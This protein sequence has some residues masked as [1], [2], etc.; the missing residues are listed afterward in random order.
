MFLPRWIDSNATCC[1]FKGI[2]KLRMWSIK[3]SL[4]LLPYGSLKLYITIPENL[5]MLSLPCEWNHGSGRI[6]TFQRT[7]L[8]FK[9]S[10]QR[11]NVYKRGEIASEIRK[12]A[13]LLLIARLALL[14]L[15]AH[16]NTECLTN[17]Q[18][19]ASP[20]EIAISF[21]TKPVKW[22]CRG[23]AHSWKRGQYLVALRCHGNAYRYIDRAVHVPI[24][25][26]S[27]LIIRRQKLNAAF[28]STRRHFQ[29]E[30][31][32][33]YGV[34]GCINIDL[35]QVVVLLVTCKLLLILMEIKDMLSY[36]Y[37]C[38]NEIEIILSL[39]YFWRKQWLSVIVNDTFINFQIL[40]KS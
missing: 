12:A 32:Q 35:T 8:K 1:W 21:E 5:K 20:V 2:W 6:N 14:K 17:C 36:K 39:F 25:E 4:L 26:R 38:W 28:K 27:S 33:R 16:H 15:W 34:W 37:L 11:G 24:L 22:A 10:A 7:F 30:T 29:K 19:P 40:S 13:Y 18:Y 23:G 3:L 9:I 31:N